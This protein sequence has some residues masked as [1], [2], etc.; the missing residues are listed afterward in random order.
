V[1]E[2]EVPLLSP[3]ACSPVALTLTR[4]ICDTA[5]DAALPKLTSKASADRT[6]PIFFTIRSHFP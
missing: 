2:V 1:P 4:T 3:F 5:A 6:D